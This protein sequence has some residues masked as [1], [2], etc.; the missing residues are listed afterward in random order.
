MGEGTI[1]SNYGKVNGKVVLRSGVLRKLK[2][3]CAE[4]V[5]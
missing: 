4:R 1:L 2:S 5:E 3:L